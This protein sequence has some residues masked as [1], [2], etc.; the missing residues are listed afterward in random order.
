MDTTSR[1]F[2]D[3]P[4]PARK[5]RRTEKEPMFDQ[6]PEPVHGNLNLADD[7]GFQLDIDMDMGGASLNSRWIR[8]HTQ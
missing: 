5:R 7:M 2:S 8:N 6:S 1:L 3:S 4:E